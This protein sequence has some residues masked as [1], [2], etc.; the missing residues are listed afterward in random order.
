MNF[1]KIK[2]KPRKPLKSVKD[3]EYYKQNKEEMDRKFKEAQEVNKTNSEIPDI[4]PPQSIVA[5]IP[6]DTMTEQ[7]KIYE[8]FFGVESGE[9]DEKY[10]ELQKQYLKEKEELGSGCSGCKLNGL[11]NKYRQL[12][13]KI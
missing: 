1:G 5:N 7:D 3:S 12:I 9:L 2:V 4:P 11:M 13:R 10:L 6:Q 8:I